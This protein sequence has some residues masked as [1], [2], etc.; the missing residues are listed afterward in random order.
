MSK[1]LASII[2]SLNNDNK[3][4]SKT[5]FKKTNEILISYETVNK[6]KNRKR[7]ETVEVPH[8]S[9]DRM[10]IFSGQTWPTGNK[11]SPRRPNKNSAT[12]SKKVSNAAPSAVQ[13]K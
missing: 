3:E 13:T 11:N 7:Q 5:E 12:Q 2:I 1:I 6:G 4:E 9:C 10:C 8:D